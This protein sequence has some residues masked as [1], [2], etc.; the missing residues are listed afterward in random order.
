ML[1]V[2]YIIR[3]ITSIYDRIAYI[4]KQDHCNH[5]HPPATMHAPWEPRMPP[6]NHACPLAT[7]HTPRN[8]AHPLQ[9]HTPPSNHACPL[10]TTHTPLAT[11]HTP[12][13]NHACPPPCGQNHR[14]LWKYNLAPCPCGKNG[15]SKFPIDKLVREIEYWYSRIIWKEHSMGNRLASTGLNQMIH[16]YLFLWFHVNITCKIM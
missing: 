2:K 11:T 9:P 5:A 15:K 10:A 13:G 7:M 16:M 8:H 4:C 1:S 14:R 3:Q 12:P 6:R